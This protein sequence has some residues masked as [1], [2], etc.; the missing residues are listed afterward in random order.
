MNGLLY[1]LFFH[2]YCVVGRAAMV[3]IRIKRTVC[4]GYLLQNFVWAGATEL[5]KINMFHHI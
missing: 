5:G 1:L 3:Y 2:G 4:L